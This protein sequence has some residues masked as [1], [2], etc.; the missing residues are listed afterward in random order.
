MGFK[1][2]FK[3]ICE[4]QEHFS[5]LYWL[6]IYASKYKTHVKPSH[7]FLIFAKKTEL[8]N[9]PQDAVRLLS[10][11]RTKL[12]SRVGHDLANYR[13]LTKL[14]PSETLPVVFFNPFR[15]QF[16]YAIASFTEELVHALPFDL[17]ST[18]N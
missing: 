15:T 16:S 10:R 4:H 11:L 6:F 17:Q 5:Q 8:V 13:F 7:N 18:D 9:F 3:N 1:K 14:I 12:Q 2:L